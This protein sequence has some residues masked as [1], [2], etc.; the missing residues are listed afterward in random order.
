M[1]DRGIYIN[2]KLVTQLINRISDGLNGFSHQTSNKSK[3][4]SHSES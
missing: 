1:R 2:D 4:S 3:L